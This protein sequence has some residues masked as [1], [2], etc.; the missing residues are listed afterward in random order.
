MIKRILF[1]FFMVM[2]F[3]ADVPAWSAE[4]EPAASIQNI[5]VY[6]DSAMIRK[7]SVFSVVKGQNII[8]IP[9]ITPSLMDDS[10]QVS[11]PNGKGVRIADVKVE[12]TYL[13]ETRQD[14]IE[15]LKSRLESLEEQ[16]KARTNEITVLNSSSD[17]LKKVMPF[18]KNLKTTPSEVDAHVKF[19]TRSLAEN[20]EKIARTESRLKKLEE[21]KKAVERELKDLSAVTGETKNI[22][23]SA[24][25]RDDQKKITLILSYLVSAA[26][27]S[28]QYDLRANSAAHVDMDCFATLRQYTGED[29]K[30][31]Q[32]EISTAKPFVYG[33]PPE[34]RPWHVDIF[35]PRPRML[36]SAVR[37]DQAD[38]QAMAPMEMK[39]EA[40]AGSGYEMP[41]VK[42]ETS[43][44]SFAL[45][46]RV[47]V[48]S[49]NQPHKILIASAGRDSKFNYYAVPKLSKYSYLRAELKNPFA[50]PILE[51]PMNV[52]LD[53]R[54]VG[55]LSLNKTLLAD[56]DMNLSLG[57]DEGIKVEKK[58]VKKFTEYAGTFT[59]ETKIHYEYVIDIVNGKNR[60]VTLM[61][62]DSVPVSRNEKIKVEIESPKKEEA[63][64]SEEGILTW[65]LK[66][67]RSEKKSLKIKFY[68]E[69]PKDLRIT[70]LE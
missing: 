8:R 47:D 43:S 55:T 35:Q 63:K 49:D 12:K 26:G 41:E 40:E 6:P 61:V 13:T 28:P 69:Y 33:A 70:G 32:M 5:V 34:L 62:N 25:A 3:S 23:V 42:A 64:I 38:L 18:P 54:L 60:D 67:A 30:G 19:F 29:W 51:G 65:D 10:V 21:E 7:Q 52:F 16:I 48:P 37:K 50:F 66:L 9:G 56:E 2:V 58:P 46:A 4:I 14:K 53:D 36:K 44:F 15:K 24:F 20:Y 59:K 1:S 45:P 27:W 11:F 31:V 39:R 57:V 22:V 68:V 17:F